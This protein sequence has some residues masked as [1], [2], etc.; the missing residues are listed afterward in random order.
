MQKV[1]FLNSNEFIPTQD[2][3][4]VEPQEAEKET[5]TESGIILGTAKKESALDV[6]TYGKVL[7]CGPDVEQVEIGDFVFWPQTDGLEFEF[8]DGN[9]RLIGTRSIIGIH[10]KD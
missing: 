4:L 6:P 7:S 8:K 1:T 2:F 5:V 9:F 10:K 3:I